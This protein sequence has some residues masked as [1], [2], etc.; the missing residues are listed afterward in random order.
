[1][2]GMGGQS[3]SIARLAGALALV[4]LLATPALCTT[5]LRF[6]LD[7]LIER[8][9][10]IVHGECV[11]VEGRETPD[12]VVTEV[13]LRVTEILKG[14]PATTFSFT[15]YGGMTPK[16]GT[17]IAGSP[18]FEVGEELVVFLDRPNRHGYRMAI[19]MSQG[20]YTVREEGGRK[21]AVR[22]LTGLRLIDPRTGAVEE[23]SGDEQGLPLADLLRTVKD[24]VAAQPPRAGEDR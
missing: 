10:V 23:G 5:V 11:G 1:M 6:S 16:R 12:G 18:K 7:E 9:D 15:T 22:N 14:A 13:Q 3:R 19:G 4:L 2:R 8:A 17:F 21:V 20:K 24:A